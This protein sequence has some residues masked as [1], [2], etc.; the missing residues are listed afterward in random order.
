MAFVNE[1]ENRRTIDPETGAY[2]IC[3][4]AAIIDMPGLHEFSFYWE[5]ERIKMYAQ[6]M[7]S[8]IE[9]VAPNEKY[10][11]HWKFFQ[12]QIPS[13]M[14]NKRMEILEMI[15]QAYEVHG[16]CYSHRNLKTVTAEF[17]PP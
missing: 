15:K 1:H 7:I 6:E 16:D 5:G 12:V 3:D 17:I 8:N 4:K 11:V 13:N 2:L 9:G 10:D 14:Q